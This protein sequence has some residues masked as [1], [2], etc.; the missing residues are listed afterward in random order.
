MSTHTH[1]SSDVDPTPEFD[2]RCMHYVRGWQHGDMLASDVIINLKE[3]SRTAAT[4]G[5]IANEARAEH[6]SGYMQHYMGNWNISI[7]HYEK[8]RQL[9]VRVSNRA[10]VIVMDINQGENYRYSGKFKHA[11]NL[12]HKA[13]EAAVA[14]QDIRLQT[15]AITNEGLMLISLQDFDKAEIALQRGLELTRQWTDDTNREALLTEVYYGLAQIALHKKTHEQAWKYAHY[16]LNHARQGENMHSVGLAYRILGDVITV[17]DTVPTES[18]FTTPESYYGAALE[19]FR[20]IDADAEIARTLYSHATSYAKRK[21]RRHA[22]Q[23][24]REAMVMFTR[25]GMTDDAASAAE[26]QL[27]II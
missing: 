3:L 22:A 9:F 24:F 20:E 5:H 25:L 21:R 11:R 8:A 2:A 19:T 27:Q 10:R 13:Y 23:L 1:V 7:M 4:A 14:I 6:L 16:S 17:L 12:Y 15:L 18:D 26:A